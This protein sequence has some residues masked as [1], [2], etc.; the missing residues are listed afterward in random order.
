MNKKFQYTNIINLFTIFL[1]SSSSLLKGAAFN[2]WGF[3]LIKKR[4]NNIF[5]IY[6]KNIIK[7]YNE[8]T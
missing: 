8:N 3:I 2:K 5:L 7:L 6:S 4:D 1:F